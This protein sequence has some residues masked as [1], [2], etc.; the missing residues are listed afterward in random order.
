M[1]LNFLFA[2]NRKKTDQSRTP[3][4]SVIDSQAG[5]SCREKSIRDLTPA[6]PRNNSPAKT[7]NRDKKWRVLFVGGEPLW[8]RQLEND[9]GH[10]RPDWKCRFAPNAQDGTSVLSSASFDAVILDSQTSH[11]EDL[12]T[13]L[14]KNQRQIIRL[15]RCN[16]L[17]REV[18]T[19]WNR[20]GVA[21]IPQDGDTGALVASLMREKSLN[22][23]M[24]NPAIKKLLPLIHKLPTSPQLYSKI[25][26]E[27]QSPHGS[28]ETV[29]E[30]ISN[31]PIMSAKILQMAN[32][33]FFGLR[34]EITDTTEAALIL[35][36]QQIRSLILL[37]SIFAQYGNTRCPS[38]SPEPV[39]GH[40]LQ[41]GKFARTIA[42]AETRNAQTA[43]AAFTAGLLHDVGK[44]VLAANCP[45]MYDTV[46]RAQINKH[47]SHREAELEMLGTTHAELGAC[48]L[49]S[50]GLPPPILEAVAWHHQ[51]EQSEQ[52]G[53]T[54]LT[55][56]YVANAF[57]N[58][59]THS[60]EEAATMER[61]KSLY[62]WRVGARDSIIG[63]RQLCGL[64]TALSESAPHLP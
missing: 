64:S 60:P 55:A 32:S 24:A 18:V 50:W 1:N 13:V 51:P 4:V 30:L 40:S 46:C 29:A 31:D 27:L 42:L 58:E 23:W 8:F 36:D 37:A 39:W 9:L 12:L 49:A 2:P 20:L 45:K 56:V 22:N 63:W 52:E 59:G 17:D 14:D 7:E 48:L 15:V 10:T 33:A 43:E 25:T 11:T 61:N 57:A 41:V 5:E 38:F 3:S 21:P 53:F 54:L 28:M 35:G 47:I 44:L 34:R 26:K 6:V 19:K 62:L 16:L